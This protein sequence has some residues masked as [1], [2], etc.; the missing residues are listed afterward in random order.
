[1]VAEAIQRQ[2]VGFHVSIAG[3]LP[4]SVRR[5][6]ERGCTAFQVFCGNPRG[7]AMA[8]RTQEELAGF[9]SARARAGL[10]PLVAHACY[11]INVCAPDAGVFGR[12]IRRLAAELRAAAAMGADYY[13]LHPGSHRGMPARWGVAR[14]ADGILKALDAAPDAP[15]LLLEDMASPHG[16]GGDLARLGELLGRLRDGAAGCRFGLALDSCHAFGAGYDMRDPA[17]VERLIGDVRRA[18]GLAALRLIHVNDSRDPPG[19]GRDRHAHIGRGAIG[20]KGLANLLR[21]PALR[22]LPLILETP[23]E[24]VDVDRRN[25][26]AVMRML[27]GA[28]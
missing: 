25:L 13:V 10:S 3:G 20:S 6:V 14:A 26:R 4:R 9:G 1:M 2:P 18:T 23:W 24:S 27:R 15:I 16:P 5:A 28:C 19:S 7:W 8:E 22:G 12:S 17:E 21:H 11:L